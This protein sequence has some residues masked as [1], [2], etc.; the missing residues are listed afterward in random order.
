M[1]DHESFEVK[2]PWEV[3]RGP[4]TLG[5]DFWWHLG[6]DT[7]VT[8]EWGTPN[9][10]EEGL[11]PD[12]L[13]SGGYGNALHIW[14]LPTRTHKKVLK[15]G[16]Q[17]QMALICCPAHDP[18]KAYGFLGVVVSIEDLSSSIWLWYLDGANGNGSGE[19]K[20]KKVIDIPAKPANPDDLPPLLKGFGAVPPLVTATV[21][22]LDDRYLYVSCW[23]TGEL[24]RYDVSDPFA[25][26]LAGSA[27]IG[28]IVNR[29]AHPNQP[30][31]PLSGGPQMV[32]ASRDGSRVYVT[33]SLYSTWDPQFYPDG[34]GGW[35]AKLDV[36][37]RG[38]KLD[39]DFFLEFEDGLR[40]H[41]VR[42]EGGDASS[43]S[44]CFS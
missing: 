39:R 25:P 17:Y 10:I 27:R 37:E 6:H 4:Q 41:Q 32:E 44:F 29:T 19:W 42:L 5:Y 30:D 3:D 35:M 24:L 33:N 31:K 21:L 15:L 23:G 12:I 11:N 40:P 14:D 18:R 9:M 2:G 34:L 28:G 22:S 8:S 26:V 7:M 13:L 36:D 1:L 43:D 16:D 38:M 20:I